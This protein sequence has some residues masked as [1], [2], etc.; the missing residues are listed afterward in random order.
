MLHVHI[1]RHLNA[2]TKD[3]KYATHGDL[4]VS[5]CISLLSDYFRE[6]PFT[7]DLYNL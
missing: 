5:L 3:G 1:L 7:Y 4:L 6:T 2:H